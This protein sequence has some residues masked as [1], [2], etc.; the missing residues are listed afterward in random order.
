VSGK[1]LEMD[2]VYPN[3]GNSPCGETWRLGKAAKL[4]TLSGK[5]TVQTEVAAR[6]GAF[7]A[8]IHRKKELPGF[9]LE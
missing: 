1:P 3:K 8:S 9:Q 5:V 7:A 2:L 4:I 6:S